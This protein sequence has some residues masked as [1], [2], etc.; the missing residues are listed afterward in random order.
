MMLRGDNE[1]VLR[2]LCQ[3]AYVG[4]HEVLCRVLG[5]Y[6]MYVDSRDV[7]LASHLMLEGFWEM[8]V[9]HVISTLIDEGMVV[10]DVGANL[11]YYTI[12]LSELVGPGGYVHAFEPNPHLAR[13]LTKNVFVNGFEARVDVHQLALADQNDQEMALIF[14]EDD[15]KN[16]FMMPLADDLPAGALRV[17]VARLDSRVDWEA[18]EFAK[19]DVEGAEE[20]VWAGMQGMLDQSRLKTVLLEFTPARYKDP[21]AFLDAI[22]K[23]GF[24]LGRIDYYDGIVEASRAQVLNM[25][26]PAEDVML[27]LRR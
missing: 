4:D 14:R 3:T 25:P 10:A 7:G 17:P 27:V 2:A 21:V 24:S 16:G 23:P 6:K 19:I 8:W 26:N 11:G 9:T 15:P 5:R 20:L 13:L 18:V 1:A 12:I 22:L